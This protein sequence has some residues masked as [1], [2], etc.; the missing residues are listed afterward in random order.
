MI[1]CVS[2]TETSVLNNMKERIKDMRVFGCRLN[3]WNHHTISTASAL[4]H[5]K[6]LPSIFFYFHLLVNSF[7]LRFEI[8]RRI[9]LGNCEN[10]HENV[11]RKIHW[12]H[13]YIRPTAVIGNG[14]G[15]VVSTMLMLQPCGINYI[16]TFV[17]QVFPYC[18]RCHASRVQ[19]VRAVFY[20]KKQ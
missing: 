13:A 2:L 3:F 19:A 9:L 6:G 15:M 14:D 10:Y 20:P 7:F 18:H 12:I 16:I 11:K 4:S 8:V 5:S 1:P 17:S